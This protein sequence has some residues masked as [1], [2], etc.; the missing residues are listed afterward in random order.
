MNDLIWTDLGSFTPE[1]YEKLVK[2]A[3][4]TTLQKQRTLE[5]LDSYSVPNRFRNAWADLAT[6]YEEY[7]QDKIQFSPRDL[8]IIETYNRSS[9]MYGDGLFQ[10]PLKSEVNTSEA[11][12]TSIYDTLSKSHGENDVMQQFLIDATVLISRYES[13]TLWLQRIRETK[14]KNKKKG[15][16]VLPIVALSILVMFKIIPEISY[17][18]IVDYL[19][20]LIIPSVPLGVW[21]YLQKNKFSNQKNI[22][23][24]LD[25]AQ[26]VADWSLRRANEH[27]LIQQQG[28]ESSSLFFGT[29]YHYYRQGRVNSLREAINLFYQERQYMQLAQQQEMIQQEVNFAKNL[30]VANTIYTLLK[31]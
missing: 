20:V 12:F 15:N 27:P 8:E 5:G 6:S 13:A 24:Q 3:E 4:E 25:I 26:K 10:A 11:W 21:L 16:W 2:W 9:A 1:D 19:K 30:A 22:H 23:Q 14:D 17:Y 18:S 29:L 28:N 31:K 7:L